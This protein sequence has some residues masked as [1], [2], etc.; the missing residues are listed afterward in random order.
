MERIGFIGLGIMGAPMAQNL[1]KAGYYLHVYDID[2]DRTIAVASSGCSNASSAYHVARTSDIIITMVPDTPELEQVIWGEN[3]IID[4]VRPDSLFIDMS[5]IASS[6][7]IRMH[8]AL[9]AKKVQVLDAPVSGGQTGAEQATLSIMVGGSKQA[10]D[11]ALPVLKVM[12]KNIVH[13][14]GPGAG[15][16]AKTCNQ[17]IVA[18][19]IQ[20]VAEALTLAKKAGIDAA[21]V[22]EALL[23]GFA[24]SRILDVHGQ[25]MLDNNYQPG[26]KTHLQRK[27]LNIALQTGNELAVPL[28]G[29]SQVAALLDAL[30]ARGDA[31]LDHSALA[32]LMGEMSGID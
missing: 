28:P 17:I 14:G 2:H 27:D 5:T 4:A 13:I 25:R 6:T 1:I 12:G 10:F 31:E 7:A 32:K 26:F 24:Q 22:R 30:I 29:S 15:Q 20:G 9:V 11:R 18:L 3:G 23:G 19:T 8:D 21:K 16:M